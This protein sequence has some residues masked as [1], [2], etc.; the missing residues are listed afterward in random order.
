MDRTISAELKEQNDVNEN[1]Y[2]AALA[3][4]LKTKNPIKLTFKN[5]EYEVNMNQKVNGVQ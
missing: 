4:S 1:I 5:L 2:E 3:A